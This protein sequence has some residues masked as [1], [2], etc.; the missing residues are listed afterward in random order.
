MARPRD[1]RLSRSVGGEGPGVAL[2]LEDAGSY[3]PRR[4][5]VALVV[6][7][8]PPVRRLVSRV[9]RHEGWSVLEAADASSAIAL[10][11]TGP[12][13]LLVTDYEMPRVTGVALAE[14]LRER[15]ED[16][17]VL[18]VSGRPEAFGAMRRLH[19]RTAFR[20]KPFAVDE[21]ISTV[22]SIVG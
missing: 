12:L 8:E 10:A 14:Q 9:L 1:F 3:A 15:D 4:A 18:V 22:G 17:P 7:D 20:L 13:D 19:G 16:L 21:L 2:L 5:R 6:D 11:G